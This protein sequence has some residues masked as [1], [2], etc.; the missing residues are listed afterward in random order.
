MKTVVLDSDYTHFNETI[1]PITP[2]FLLNCSSLMYLHFRLEPKARLQCILSWLAKKSLDCECDPTMM[3]R[4]EKMFDFI[5]DPEGPRHDLING[6][7]TR[8]TSG[9]PQY[10]YA[11]TEDTILRDPDTNVGLVVRHRCHSSLSHYVPKEI[12]CF[13]KEILQTTTASCMTSTNPATQ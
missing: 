5:V 9:T 2:I 10:E 13:K 11:S 12:A 8:R 4:M 3:M 6:H 7:W 1:G